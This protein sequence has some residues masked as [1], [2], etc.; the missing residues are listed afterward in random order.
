[1]S[2]QISHQD[3]KGVKSFLLLGWKLSWG[4]NLLTLYWYSKR[5]CSEGQLHL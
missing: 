1:M 3:I 2:H 5:C 4:T